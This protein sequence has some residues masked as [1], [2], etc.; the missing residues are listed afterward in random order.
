[1]RARASSAEGEVMKLTENQQ[2]VMGSLVSI[3]RSNVVRY[4]ESCRHLYQDQLDK[5]MRGDAASV[6]GSGGLTFQV[7]YALGMKS[8]SVLS[9]FK[10][11]ERKGMVIREKDR[12]YL[13]ALYWWPVGLAAELSA[14]LQEATNHD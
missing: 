13:C 7:G 12:G 2:K 5:L 10:A 8:G 3:C 11:L 9:V 1:M 14:E 4:R 6:F